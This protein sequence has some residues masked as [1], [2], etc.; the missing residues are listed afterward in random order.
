MPQKPI[1][2]CVPNISEGRDRSIIEAVA[3]AVR[4]VK[5]VK[6][7]HIDPG[8]STNRTVYTFAGEPEA[9]I[10]AA[11]NL[12]E[13]AAKLIDMRT[14]QGA[15][16]RMGA[17]D[18]CPLVPIEHITT[19]EAVAYAFTL[20]E[21][22]AKELNIP[23]YLYE[24]AA[25]AQGKKL[26]I[27]YSYRR[28]LADIRNGEYE[29]FAQK[30]TDPAWKPDFGEP[31]FNPKAGQSVIGVRDFL[32]AYNINL[33]TQSVRRA[34][35]VAFD[36]REIGRIK[37][38]EKGQKVLDENNQPIRI[39][40]KL[41]HCRGI[42]WYIEEYGIAQ[43]SLNLTNINETPLHIAFEAADE[44]ARNRGLRVTGSELIG[45]IPKKCLVDA[46]I[47]FLQKQNRSIGIPEADIIQIAVK[48][49]G[50]NELQTFDPK[51][52][53]IEYLLA[54]TTDTNLTDLSVT[55]FCQ[56]VG[57]E[58]PA[59]G[60]GSVAALIGALGASLGQMVANLSANKLGWDHQVSTFSTVAVALQQAQNELLAL[61][62]ADT[63]AFNQVMQAYSLPKNSPQEIQL[64]KQAIETANYA[65]IQTPLKTA[66]TAHNILPLLQQM[67]QSGNPNS[68]TDAGVGVLALQSAIHGAILNI[69]V[70]LN[71]F[72][73]T[74]FY[75]QTTATVQQLSESTDNICHQ[76]LNFIKTKLA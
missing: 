47:Y 9:V 65:A 18:V 42:G 12:F 3:D 57:S 44:A 74:D 17:V 5:A 64:R 66:Q 43:V 2:E 6:L 21:R 4:K 56:K 73:G 62:E 24:Y 58:S 52:R 51:T 40:G 16:P 41:K 32:V 36:I 19:E 53:I 25:D 10:E 60:G 55:R 31:V 61:V 29:G 71:S 37:L 8:V 49:L 76:I 39:P 75:N 1:L 35:A 67:A 27:D 23:V 30:I 34:N 7:L 46:G 22:V 69:L 59:P 54:E 45:L 26:N 33:N 50:L 38:D 14:H 48:T 13:K 72:K 70:N 68:I 28:S 63:Q 15:H 11:Y 20:A